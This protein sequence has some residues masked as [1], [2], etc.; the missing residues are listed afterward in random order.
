MNLKNHKKQTANSE[1]FQ[2]SYSSKH[3][4][5]SVWSEQLSRVDWGKERM[6]F[7]QCFGFMETPKKATAAM[8]HSSRGTGGIFLDIYG[9]SYFWF[10]P[11]HEIKRTKRRYFADIWTQ[12]NIWFTL[13][14]YE[15]NGPWSNFD[16]YLFLLL[17]VGTQGNISCAISVALYC[18][19]A[20]NLCVLISLTYQCTDRD[21]KSTQQIQCVGSLLTC[22]KGSKED[23]I[24]VFYYTPIFPQSDCNQPFSEP[25][26]SFRD[27]S[28][29]GTF[30]LSVWE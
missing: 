14:I 17:G 2:Y 3:K 21:R 6:V 22:I 5:N 20:K 4:L 29:A 7:S 1:L 12:E 30:F 8:P 25:M 15:V 23:V 19:E 16:W 26:L 27:T 18:M 10:L 24:S 28:E 11:E 9:H 13:G